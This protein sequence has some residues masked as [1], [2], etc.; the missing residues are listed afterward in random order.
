MAALIAVVEP[1][2]TKNVWLAPQKSAANFCAACRDGPG[3]LRLSVASN[4]VVSMSIKL[5][6]ICEG[7]PQP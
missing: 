5:S 4:S 2:V 6:F 3:E 1:V 7:K